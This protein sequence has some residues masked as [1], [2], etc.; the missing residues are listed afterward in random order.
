MS[1]EEDGREIGAGETE[2]MLDALGNAERGLPDAGFE[3]RVMD[4]VCEQVLAPAPIRFER[5]GGAWWRDPMLVGAAAS[6]AIVMGVVGM[7]WLSGLSAGPS[8]HGDVVITAAE[9]VE[10]FVETVAWLEEGLPDFA[11]L[12][13]Q[14]EAI[15]EATETLLD[16]A[17]QVLLEGEE[18]I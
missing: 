14:A 11:P 4:A 2:R 8:V 9:E 3:Q 17:A 6:I 10:A 7:L 15:G 13:E 5:G 18:S 12:E 16:E 1:R